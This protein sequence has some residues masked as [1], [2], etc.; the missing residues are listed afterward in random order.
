MTAV[1]GLTVAADAAA[2]ERIGLHVVD[3]ESWVGGVRLRFVAPASAGGSASGDGVV[4]WT[5]AGSPRHDELIDGLATD[6][7]TAEEAEA[8]HERADRSGWDHPMGVSAFDHLVVMTS[9]LERT[10]GAVEASTGEPLKRVREAGTVRQ[11]FHRLGPMILEVVESSQVSSPSAAFWG[12][13]L[14]VDDIDDLA[15]RLGPDVMSLPKAAVQPGRRIASFR[16]QIGLGLPFA[17]MSR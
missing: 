7:V 1:H 11:G 14:I 17:V 3:G 8:D 15:G 13:V 5:L 2:W 16:Q 4:G 10:C 6:H 9:S 12:F